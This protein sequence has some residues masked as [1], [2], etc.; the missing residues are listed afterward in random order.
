MLPHNK[1]AQFNTCQLYKQYPNTGNNPL[2]WEYSR[3]GCRNNK[4]KLLW[5]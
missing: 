2:G 3:N 4:I 5:K 1:Q